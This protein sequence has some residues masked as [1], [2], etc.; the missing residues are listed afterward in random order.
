M[1][2]DEVDRYRQTLKDQFPDVQ[3]YIGVSGITEQRWHICQQNPEGSHIVFMDDDIEDV[4]Y[5]F[6]PGTGGDTLKPLPVGGLEAIIHH[7]HDLMLQEKSFLW[8]FSSSANSMSLSVSDISR[9][10]GMVN[11]FLYGCRNRHD[12][13]LRCIHASPTEDVERSCRVYD[14]DRVVLRYRMYC[15]KTVFKASGGIQLLYR[16]LKERKEAEEQAIHKL[17]KEFPE[18]IRVRQGSQ[19]R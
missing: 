12:E 18:L 3:L 5:K 10:C 7:A 1:S 13:K 14:C 8:G 4:L 19:R 17:A 9:R 16:S 2:I 11:G 15:A 6:K